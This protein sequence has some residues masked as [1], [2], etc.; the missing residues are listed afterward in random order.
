M[1][2]TLG[3][4]SLIRK[5]GGQVAGLSMSLT[6]YLGSLSL[7]LSLSES[8]VG[9]LAPSLYSG[10]QPVSVS[11]ARFMEEFRHTVFLRAPSKED[12]ISLGT[13]TGDDLSVAVRGA[14]AW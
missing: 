12:G 8:K 11:G 9:V 2:E 4:P 10:R 1:L 7:L 3:D 13:G 5:F 6:T 14:G